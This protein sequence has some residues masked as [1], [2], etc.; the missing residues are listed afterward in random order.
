MAIDPDRIAGSI[1]PVRPVATPLAIHAPERPRYRV[2]VIPLEPGEQGASSRILN[3][4]AGE[5]WRVHSKECIPSPPGVEHA[6]KWPWTLLVL[7]EAI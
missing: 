1:P 4:L 3:R 7:L 5:G 2:E 6:A